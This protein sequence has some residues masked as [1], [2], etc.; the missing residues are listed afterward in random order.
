MDDP[1]NLQA[2]LPPS[3]F[4]AAN[5]ERVELQN[6]INDAFFKNIIDL[7]ESPAMTATEV[8]AR[9]ARIAKAL[10]SVVG[11]IKTDY[12]KPIIEGGILTMLR[13][14]QLLPLPEN[15]GGV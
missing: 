11:R 14:G 15:I 5:E 2:L 7:K 12:M 4:A 6:D 9:L 1:D 10:S 8:N 13:Q 3:D